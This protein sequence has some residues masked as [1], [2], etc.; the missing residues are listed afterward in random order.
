MITEKVEAA[1]KP[2]LLTAGNADK[3]HLPLCS[4]IIW[5]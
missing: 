1:D 2:G 3:Q 4:V 5:I